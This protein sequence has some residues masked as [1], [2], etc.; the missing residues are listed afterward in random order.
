MR[1]L[2]EVFNFELCSLILLNKLLVYPMYNLLSF[3]F[4][5]IYT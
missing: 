5:S 3:K 4:L 1:N 2:V